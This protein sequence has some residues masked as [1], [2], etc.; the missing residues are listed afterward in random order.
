MAVMN[1]GRI[2]EIAP[3]TALHDGSFTETYSK[4]LYAA[5]GGGAA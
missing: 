2:V 3:T 5:S 1:K 4:A